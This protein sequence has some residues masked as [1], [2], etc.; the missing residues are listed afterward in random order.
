M[1]ISMPRSTKHFNSV[2][3]MP[4]TMIITLKY[5]ESLVSAASLGV[6]TLETLALAQHPERSSLPKKRQPTLCYN[7]WD[8]CIGQ[9]TACQIMPLKEDIIDVGS[10][11]DRIGLTN[12]TPFQNRSRTPQSRGGVRCVSGISPTKPKIAIDWEDNS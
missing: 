8:K 5:L 1:P 2:V 9:Q 3:W 12:V 7:G 10:V 11:V 4:W 6:R